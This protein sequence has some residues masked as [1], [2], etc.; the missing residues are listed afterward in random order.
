MRLALR[1]AAAA[2]AVGFSLGAAAQLL[3]YKPYVSGLH[4]AVGLVHANDGSGRLFVV[5]QGGFIRVVRNAALES[6]PF[7]DISGLIK[8]VGGEEGLLGLAL[9]PGFAANGFFYVYHNVPRAQNPADGGSNI[10]IA[11][12]HAAAGGAAETNTRFEVLRID[13]PTYANHNGGGMAFGPDGFL[14]A[15]VGDGGSGGD[16]FNAGQNLADLRGKLLRLDVD[17]ASPY[18]IPPSNP[19]V[20][21]PGARG[22]IF[23]YGLRNPWRF[24]FDRITGDLFIGD[25]GQD[26]WEE[27]DL[28]PAGTSGQNFGW[29]VFEATH[30]F[31]PATNCSLA[32]HVL[33]IL[34]Y[35]HT[36]GHSVTGGF[37]YRG[38]QFPELAGAYV[39][40]D[41]VDGR[42][43]TARPN[44]SGQW[45]SQEVTGL[46][47]VSTFGED[48]DGELFAAQYT[49]GTIFR[50]GP[51]DADGDG[52]ADAFEAANFGSTT[53]GSASADTDGDGIPNLQEYREQ[54]N[55]LVKD[56]DV[57][58]NARLFAMQQYRDF[59]AREGDVK[60][61]E[62]WQGAVAG[63]M[64]RATVIENFIHSPEFEGVIAPV[65]RLYFAYF[66]RIPDYVG[67]DFWIRYRRAGNSL[68]SI[69]DFF[70]Q[71]GEFQSR[72]GSLD[73]GQFVTLVY[74]NVL[75]RAPDAPGY[76]F[77]KGRL[78]AAAMT[79][80]QVML[81]FSESAE[82]RGSIASEVYVTMAYVGMLRRSPDP[83][84][85][86]FWVDYI[87]GGNPGTGLIDGFLA[88]SE[89][90]SRFLP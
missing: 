62:F 27:V 29:R 87:D 66:L 58:G 21:T 10:V 49:T 61:T 39:F 52:M 48:A 34:E 40:A 59:L 83:G 25:V 54:R 53:A 55:P 19:F 80:G 43:F 84:G 12:Y 24:T 45:Q 41:F 31:S 9:H 90:R 78:D 38:H 82:Y 30:C 33:P 3:A 86:S 73:N 13:H 2:L 4:E 26:L 6:T 18:A 72:Y 71:S 1:A 70:S 51:P 74:N 8:K 81:G 28:I 7:L 5:E 23:A 89:Y 20:Y 11:R 22:E 14:Y 77:W 32:G 15:S 68:E 42:V 79:R 75:G 67:L 65:T 57:F 47:Y 37:R 36:V 35:S 44:G 50:I 16:P 46:P 60:G 63:G 56:N 88:A 64:P 85:F 17:S 76:A 69:S